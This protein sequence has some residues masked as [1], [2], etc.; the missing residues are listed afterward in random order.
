MVM[1]RAAATGLSRYGECVPLLRLLPMSSRDKDAEILA[2]RHQF[3]VLQRQLGPG[4]VRFTTGAGHCWR[5]CCTGSRGTCLSGC[6]WWCVRIPCCAGTR[7]IVAPAR[8]PAPAP[9]PGAG[10]HPGNAVSGRS[11]CRPRRSP[12]RTHSGSPWSAAGL[13]GTAREQARA[14]RR[15]LRVGVTP[16]YRAEAEEPSRRRLRRG[17][18]GLPGLVPGSRLLPRGG[19]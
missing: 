15:A 7:D 19:P 4:R 6:T 14:E 16:P 17:R 18:R 1:D 3:L 11:A 2:L 13:A 8:P 10:R 9:V 12:A 5:R